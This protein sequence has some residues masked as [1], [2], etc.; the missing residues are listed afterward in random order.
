MSVKSVV[1][2]FQYFETPIHVNFEKEIEVIVKEREKHV[3]IEMV[4]GGKFQIIGLTDYK[5]GGLE[6]FEEN[7]NKFGQFRIHLDMCIPLFPLFYRC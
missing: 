2:L 4:F 1:N 7:F 5:S 3:L 6:A